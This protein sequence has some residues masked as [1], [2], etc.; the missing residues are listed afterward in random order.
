LP[1][2]KRAFGRCHPSVESFGPLD[3]RSSS[4]LPNA[5]RRRARPDGGGSTGAR[6]EARSTCGD[7]VGAYARCA[8]TAPRTASTASG[9]DAITSTPAGR[10]RPDHPGPPSSIT[11]D[12]RCAG[13][14]AT[15]YG[16]A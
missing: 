3:L 9:S 7:V 4:L 16:S 10:G 12:G 2:V 15:A 1:S 13:S 5:A 14:P 6:H 11:V 8:V